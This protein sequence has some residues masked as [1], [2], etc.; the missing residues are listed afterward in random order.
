MYYTFNTLAALNGEN[1][2]D[3]LR[4]IIMDDIHN[5]EM[6]V[7]IA[8][9]SA[10][11]N[12]KKAISESPLTPK[13]RSYIEVLCNRLGKELPKNIDK[14]TV[15]MADEKIKELKKALAEV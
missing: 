7:S 2:S 12:E 3:R 9:M 8:A 14:F 1:K 11:D 15:S 13:Q 6:S 5:T 10:V 4:R